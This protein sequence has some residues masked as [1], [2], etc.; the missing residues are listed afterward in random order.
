MKEEPLLD[1]TKRLLRHANLR[2]RKGLGQHF[3]IDEDVL[4]VILQAAE[5]TPDDTVIEVGPG[6]GIMTAALAKKAGSVIAVELDDKLAANLKKSPASFENVTVINDDILNI[7]V[8]DLLHEKKKY[9]VVANLPYYITSPTIRR[10]LESE[11]KPQTM[12]LM[13]QKEVAEVIAAKPGQMS[14]MSVSVQYYGNP[15]II[16]YVPAK[17]FYPAPEVDSAVIRIDVYPQPVVNV[18]EKSFF[19]LVRAGFTA[20]R[21]QIANSL[22][23]GLGLLKPDILTLLEKA[24]IAPQRRAEALTIQ[25]WA[26]LW[27]VFH[28]EKE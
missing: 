7:D 11:V 6:L 24:D 2:A 23:Q 14:L 25:E 3:L 15:A 18:C 12:I 8:S 27:E 5:L 1:Q 10:F 28:R 17:S 16:E 13:V 19:A 9:K 21:K 4:E 26:K 20:S 22:A